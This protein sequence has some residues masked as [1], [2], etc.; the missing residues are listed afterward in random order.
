M[1][2]GGGGGRRRKILHLDQLGLQVMSETL[3]VPRFVLLL[4]SLFVLFCL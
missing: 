2:E 4:L 3:G 1:G